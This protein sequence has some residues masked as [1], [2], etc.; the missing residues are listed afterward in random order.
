MLGGV[1]IEFTDV[2]KV[3]GEVRSAKFNSVEVLSLWS[4]L[5]PDMEKSRSEVLEVA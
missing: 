4:I 1:F 5:R 2:K 3:S